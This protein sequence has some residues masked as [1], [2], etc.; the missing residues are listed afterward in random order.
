MLW[1]NYMYISERDNWWVALD[2]GK[3]NCS[4]ARPRR[5]DV[6]ATLQEA[7]ASEVGPLEVSSTPWEE[8]RGRVVYRSCPA[9]STEQ[10][11]QPNALVASP[12]AVL[13]DCAD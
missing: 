13:R 4:E 10:P 11:L 3:K 9:A 5:A 8:E 12:C 2:F 7:W 1:D 6:A